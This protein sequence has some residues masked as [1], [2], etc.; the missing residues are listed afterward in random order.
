MKNVL[1]DQEFSFCVLIEKFKTYKGHYREK[2]L[3]YVK[4]TKLAG[5]LG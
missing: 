4:L 5:I 3:S 1:K 2:K